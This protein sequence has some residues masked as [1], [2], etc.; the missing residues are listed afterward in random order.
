MGLNTPF[1]CK[2]LKIHCLI[3]NTESLNDKTL[4]SNLIMTDIGRITKENRSVEIDSIFILK[5]DNYI[6]IYCILIDNNV[7][8]RKKSIESIL[9]FSGKLQV[10]DIIGYSKTE[11]LNALKDDINNYWDIYSIPK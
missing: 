3:S 1:N 11:L 7:I 2:N 10:L 9:N 6:N 8:K 4:I 5:K